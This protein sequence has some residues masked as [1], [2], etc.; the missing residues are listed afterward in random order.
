MVVVQ[1]AADIARIS[2]MLANNFM[3]ENLT[4]T[5]KEKA[6]KVIT[7]RTVALDEVIIREGDKGDEM[8]IIDRCTRDALVVTVCCVVLNVLNLTVFF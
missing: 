5:Q 1:S 2:K 8:Y 4:V 6:Y 7:S 3:F